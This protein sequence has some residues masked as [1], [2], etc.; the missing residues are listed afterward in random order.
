MQFESALIGLAAVAAAL[1]L[2]GM[3]V[4]AG[5]LAPQ[6]FKRLPEDVATNFM[7]EIFPGFYM[8]MLVVAAIGAAA[9]VAVRPFE[10]GALAIVGVGFAMSRWWLAPEAQRLYDARLRDEPGAPERFARMHKRSSGLFM[11][12]I[13]ASLMALLGL[14]IGT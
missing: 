12:Q 6:V 9:A 11:A 13:L 8:F 7:R 4:F 1:L 14:A 2:G 10:A 3:I 5:Y